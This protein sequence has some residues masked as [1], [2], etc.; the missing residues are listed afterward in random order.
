VAEAAPAH[1]AEATAVTATETAA[2]EPVGIGRAPSLPWTQTCG[3]CLL[4]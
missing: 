2:A 4:D 1:A 3:Y